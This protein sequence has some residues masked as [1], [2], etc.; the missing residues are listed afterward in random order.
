MARVR[1]ID[2]NMPESGTDARDDVIGALRAKVC[3]KCHASLDWMKLAD[4]R[5]MEIRVWRGVGRKPLKFEVACRTCSAV[6]NVDVDKAAAH[7]TCGEQ[8]ASA[9]R[10]EREHEREDIQSRIDPRYGRR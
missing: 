5:P 1:I 10:A 7:V 9:L 2:I 3:P 6:L 4:L 8:A